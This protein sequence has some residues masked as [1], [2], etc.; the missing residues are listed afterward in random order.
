MFTIPNTYDE[1]YC[2]CDEKCPKCGRR[3]KPTITRIWC[4]TGT[5]DTFTTAS[6]TSTENPNVTQIINY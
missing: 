5:S 3:Y 2:D 6:F 4:R 1:H